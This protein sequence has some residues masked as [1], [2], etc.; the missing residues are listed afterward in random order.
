MWYNT[1]RASERE[2]ERA[3]G[4]PKGTAA[5]ISH[6]FGAGRRTARG[7]VAHGFARSKAGARQ[8]QGGTKGESQRNHGICRAGLRVGQGKSKRNQRVAF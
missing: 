1:P 7:K 4:D 3:E 2:K 5:D 6:R 8:I